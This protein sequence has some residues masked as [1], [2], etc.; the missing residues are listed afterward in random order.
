MSSITLTSLR[1]I[2]GDEGNRTLD[3]GVANA[4]LSQLSYIPTKQSI[5]HIKLYPTGQFKKVFRIF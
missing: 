4:A 2:G 3:L 1:R 5:F